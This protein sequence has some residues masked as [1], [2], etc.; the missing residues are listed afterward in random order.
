MIKPN[1]LSKIK[2]EGKLELVEP[3]EEVCSSYLGKADKCLGSAKLLLQNDYYENSITMSYFAMYNPLIALL[4][5]CGIKSE[6]HSASIVLFKKLFNNTRLFDIISWAKKERIDKQYYIISEKDNI[7]TKDAAQ[8]MLDKAE[9]F[10]IG[11]KLL[12]QNLKNDEIQK[13]RENFNKAILD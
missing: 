3:S 2:R 1:F 4:F 12:I 5:K 13:A 8:D 10:L 9:N 6:S 7:L 11:I